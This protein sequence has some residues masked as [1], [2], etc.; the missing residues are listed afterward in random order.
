MAMRI[1]DSER[2]TP[3]ERN[4]HVL[5]IEML[6]ASH[7]DCLWL[8]YGTASRIQRVLIDG[9][10]AYSYDA[11]AKRLE[12]R[13]G[14]LPERERRFE[15]LIITHVDS[16]HIGGILEFLL[17]HPLAIT[18]GDVWFNGW[19]HLPGAAPDVLG[20]VQG[21]QVSALLK[22]RF[23]WNTA[24]GR[25][26]VVVPETGDLPTVTLPGG[27]TLTLLSPTTKGLRKL[28]PK[29]KKTVEEAGMA[30]GSAED[31]LAKLREKGRELPPDVLGE[32]SPDPRALAMQPFKP[33]TSVANGS[34]IAVLAE[35]G[36]KSCLL[37]GDALAG[38]VAASVTRLAKQ[39]GTTRLGVGALKLSH[40]GG[41]SNTSSELLNL[42]R[43][44][45]YLFSTDGSR[46]QHPDPQ[47]VARTIMV[48]GQRTS[49]YFNYRTAINEVWDDR[50]LKREFGYEAVFPERDQEGMVV[51]L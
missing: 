45:R 35:H 46:F 1:G 30:A 3:N 2:S 4:W 29:W 15:L 14:P 48:A 43:C 9:G 12:A 49:L 19:D 25:N 31:A 13:L 11:L 38:V 40:H 27:L 6:P 39:R 28:R 20:A 37:T 32:V 50:A 41:K 10:P 44:Q 24:F 8:E 51:E 23:P 36:N 7:G 47:S 42:L 26:A 33:D 5:T 22:G 17:A 18:V 16:D 21:E 34:S